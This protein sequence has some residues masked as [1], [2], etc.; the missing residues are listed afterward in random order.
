MAG[1]TLVG[2]GLIAVAVLLRVAFLGDR[3]LFRDEAASWLTAHYP[4]P[5]LVAH[6]THEAYPP[7][8]FVVLKGWTW[9]AG[10]SEGALRSLSVLFGLA[11]V[12]I[13]WRWA[14]ESLGRRAGLVALA[15][16]A[17][18]PLAIANA[19]DARMYAM[20]S[21]F[22]TLAW[23]LTWRLASG[24]SQGRRRWI[25]AAALAVAVAAE[26]WT[27]SFGLPVAGLQ[28]A[29]AVVPWIR[30][31]LLSEHPGARSH[32]AGSRHLSPLASE[33]DRRVRWTAVL[34]ADSHPAGPW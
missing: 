31:R 21:A 20:E 7:L 16:L 12:L 3:Q 26:M 4:L 33:D 18:S 13:G 9:L 27:F 2:L 23:W 5:D 30:H 1:S 22:T 17:I 19:R 29:V 14:T 28:L 25:D 34:D 8:Y 32:P 6:T 11:M 10:D 15:F 24:R